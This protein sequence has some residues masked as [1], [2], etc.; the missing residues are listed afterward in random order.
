PDPPP[1]V[2]EAAEY[3]ETAQRWLV[4]PRLSGAELWRA[5]DRAG[6]LV[7]EWRIDEGCKTFSRV[8]APDGSV[9]EETTFGRTGRR[10]GPHRQR[11]LEEGE[12]PYLD[13]RIVEERGS[14]D[15]DHPVG[16]WT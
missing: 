6:T 16:R 13:A 8:F 9:K 10:H 15:Q 5:F 4:S 3:D 14:F 1:Q 11:F 7:E 12:S 2:P